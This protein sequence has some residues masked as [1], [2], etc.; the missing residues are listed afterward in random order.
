MYSVC[1]W[2]GMMDDWWLLYGLL[3]LNP[4]HLDLPAGTLWILG[5]YRYRSCELKVPLPRV[6]LMF[7]STHL[8]YTYSIGH[9]GHENKVST[10]YLT[11]IEKNMNKRKNKHLY[12]LLYL[13]RHQHI[14]IL[15]SSIRKVV[16]VFLILIF[17]NLRFR[18][19]K[20]SRV[21]ADSVAWLFYW[22]NE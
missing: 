5:T 1:T 21:E 10:I 17:P 9:E 12:C 19:F 16:V 22:L 6:F 8:L 18:R 2:M 3:L 13:T 7:F 20:C 14:H 11:D 4:L 15:I